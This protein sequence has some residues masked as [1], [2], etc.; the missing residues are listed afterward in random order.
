MMQRKD[1]FLAVM[2]KT[3]AERGDTL[4]ILM[5]TDVLLGGTPL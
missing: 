4:L 1:E 5:L 2:Q 3:M